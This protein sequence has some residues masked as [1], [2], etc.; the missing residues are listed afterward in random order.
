M[1]NW[2]WPAARWNRPMRGVIKL[3]VVMLL[4]SLGAEAAQARLDAAGG[5]LRKALV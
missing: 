2:S 4:H 5:N 3:A 1:W